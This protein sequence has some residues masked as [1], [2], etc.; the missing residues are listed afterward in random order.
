MHQEI[1]EESNIG[2]DKLL[3]HT[4][5][6]KIFYSASLPVRNDTKANVL[7]LNRTIPAISKVWNYE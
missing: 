1:G 6:I 2:N 3:L 4:S 7:T 5:I